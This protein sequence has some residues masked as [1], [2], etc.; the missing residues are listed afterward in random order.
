MEGI[1]SETVEEEEKRIEHQGRQMESMD[2]ETNE[3]EA[4]NEDTAR[5]SILFSTKESTSKKHIKKFKELDI[6]LKKDLASK[7]VKGKKS[8]MRKL[9]LMIKENKKAKMEG[10]ASNNRLESKEDTKENLFLTL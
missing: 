6:V 3:V 1:E 4:V 5:E 2:Q 10:K 9:M 8:D 7:K